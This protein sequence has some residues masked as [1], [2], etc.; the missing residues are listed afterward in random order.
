MK[1]IYFTLFLMILLFI[2]ACSDVRRYVGRE[3]G[4]VGLR[5]KEFWGEGGEIKG[6]Y[7]TQ[8][9]DIINVG[10]PQTLVSRIL[11]LPDEKN[12]TF[13]GQWVWLYKERQ[14]KLYFDNGVLKRIVSFKSP[15]SFKE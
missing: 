13:D 6:Y 15:S 10:D 3:H 11:G 1:R 5:V 12:I 14:L 8:E 2:S 4:C 9:G 7:A